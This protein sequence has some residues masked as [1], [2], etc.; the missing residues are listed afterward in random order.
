MTL[1][2]KRSEL[3]MKYMYNYCPIIDLVS[4]SN[5]SEKIVVRRVE[6]HL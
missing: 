5:G 3:D 2:L 6:E 4:I 1:L